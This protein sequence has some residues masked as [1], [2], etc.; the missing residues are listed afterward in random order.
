MRLRTSFYRGKFVSVSNETLVGHALEATGRRDDTASLPAA[1]AV[2]RSRDLAPSPNRKSGTASGHVHL[3]T[4]VDISLLILNDSDGVR[5]V[6]PCR[7]VRIELR[8]QSPSSSLGHCA[9]RCQRRRSDLVV[10]SYATV[11]TVGI[12]RASWSTSAA[13]TR[14]R[15]FPT[16]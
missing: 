12:T 5:G 4:F 2:D 10:G 9:I 15:R 13:S 6:T 14:T 1:W 11:L 7:T 3:S 8:R 16:R